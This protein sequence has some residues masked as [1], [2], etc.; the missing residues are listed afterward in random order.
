MLGHGAPVQTWWDRQAIGLFGGDIFRQFQVHGAGLFFLGQT[1]GFAHAGRDVV[2]GSQLVSV[3]RQRL[4]HADHVEDLKAALLGLLDRFL[5]GD[6]QHRHTAQVGVGASG[7]QVRG[8]RA[9]RRQT[10]AGLACQSSISCGHEAGGLLVTG[11]H[12]LD[13]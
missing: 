5:A 12:Q 11:Q 8:A 6:H 2:S 13:L 1:E 9:E 3:L 4:H 7:D 10:N